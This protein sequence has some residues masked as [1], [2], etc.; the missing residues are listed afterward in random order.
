MPPSK[1]AVEAI[2]RRRMPRGPDRAPLQ[3]SRLCTAAHADLEV[4]EPVIRSE[5][6]EALR[7]K[8]DQLVAEY[9]GRAIGASAYR[10]A[11]DLRKVVLSDSEVVGGGET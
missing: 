2:A 8:I 6:E 5:V 3:W 9:E 4:A 7:E 1:R 11:S 10:L